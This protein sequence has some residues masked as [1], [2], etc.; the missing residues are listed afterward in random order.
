MFFSITAEVSEPVLSSKAPE[1]AEGVK[2]F[3][4]GHYEVKCSTS[5][6]SNSDTL[7]LVIMLGEVGNKLTIQ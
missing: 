3:E 6:K 4:N 1:D 5:V 2:K 7:K